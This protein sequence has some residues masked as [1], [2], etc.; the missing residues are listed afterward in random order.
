MSSHVAAVRALEAAGEELEA[1]LQAA[2]V[3]LREKQEAAVSVLRS[4]RDGDD[5]DDADLL[6][7]ALEV[8]RPLQHMS[9]G[10]GG[11]H[12]ATCKQADQCSTDCPHGAVIAAADKRRV[13]I[14]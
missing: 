11:V 14:D 8:L 4:L 7:A 10:R 3:A 12:C 1:A 13:V 9:D 2:A 6:E 5:F